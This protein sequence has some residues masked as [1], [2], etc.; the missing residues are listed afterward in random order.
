MVLQT[1]L[2]INYVIAVNQDVAHP[3]DVRDLRH[4]GSDDR[5]LSR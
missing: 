2:W 3:D 4:A 5:I 1:T